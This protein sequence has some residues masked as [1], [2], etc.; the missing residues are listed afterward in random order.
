M[1]SAQAFT[2]QP[3]PLGSSGLGE[4]GEH[5]T[6]KE[7]GKLREGWILFKRGWKPIS[8]CCVSALS[9]FRGNR[10]RAQRW[11]LPKPQLPKRGY[12]RGRCE[13]VQ[14]PLPAAMDRYVLRKAKAGLLAF[15][16]GTTG[17]AYGAMQLVLQSGGQMAMKLLKE[18][19]FYQ[20]CQSGG[21][22]PVAPDSIRAFWGRQ[23]LSPLSHQSC[24]SA[25]VGY[26]VRASV[27]PTNTKHG[28]A[29]RGMHIRIPGVFNLG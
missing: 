11:W 20:S 16:Q 2:A 10:L 24:A 23:V 19:S 21:Q 28:L 3:A 25:C 8:V 15:T 4:Q 18:N 13:H 7:G 27:F 9:R 26:F 5:W 12:M 29:V 1:L 22:F 6:K 17:A 14:L